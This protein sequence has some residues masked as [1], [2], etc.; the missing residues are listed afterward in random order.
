MS[1]L[2]S[3]LLAIVMNTLSGGGMPLQ[4]KET[5][6]AAKELCKEAMHTT[7]TQCINKN[8]QLFTKCKK[9]QVK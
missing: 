8:E 6:F 5:S 3:I 2:V 1:T 4:A 9:E 7:N